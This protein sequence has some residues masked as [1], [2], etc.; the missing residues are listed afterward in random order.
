M[1]T[2]TFLLAVISL[3]SVSVLADEVDPQVLTE[4]VKNVTH[5]EKKLDGPGTIAADCSSC[6]TI[7]P[8]KKLDLKNKE[9]DLG[10]PWFKK[11]NVP[12]IIHFKRT[13]DTPQKLTVKFKN[14]HTVCAKMFV[15]ANPYNGALMVD[16][17]FRTTVYE[18]EE[19]ELNF[20]KLP[21]P[22]DGEEQIIEVKLV[23]PEIGNTFYTL[24]SEVLKGPAAKTIK[25][26][27]FWGY[28]YNLDY[29]EVKP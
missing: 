12:Y 17:L 23:K 14:S 20:K 22:S 6:K 4:A 29:S 5:L 18:D 3:F 16:C 9:E 10:A 11:N 28:G 2:C 27:K 1:K 26:K 13:K 24:E 21:P 8:D 7:E 15:G 19:L 25:D